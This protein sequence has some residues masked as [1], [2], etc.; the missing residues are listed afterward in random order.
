MSILGPVYTS[1]AAATSA[2]GWTYNIHET[3]KLETLTVKM[4]RI[5]LWVDGERWESSSPALEWNGME[6]IS[7]INRT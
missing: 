7:L 3:I 4:D 1:S 6:Y 2:L 5:D